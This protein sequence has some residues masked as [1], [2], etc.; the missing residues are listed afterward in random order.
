MNILHLKNYPILKQLQLEEALLRLSK[1]N[2]CLINEGSPPA[3]VMGISGKPEDL[4]HFEN[5]EKDPIPLIKR[6]SGG[7]TVVV[8]EQ[9][10]F[11]SFLCQKDLHD[12]A[13]YPEPIMRWSEE[14]YKPVL[15]HPQ[16][17]LRE[18]DY[19]IG[20]RKFGGNAQYLSRDRWLHHT[21]FLWDYKKERMDLLLHPKKTP[22]Y[23][24][25][26]SHE[27]FITK[28]SDYLPNKNIFVNGIKKVLQS[29]Y[30]ALEITIDHL[31]PL[32]EEPHR[33]STQII[34]EHHLC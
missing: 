24:A 17:S 34:P 1:E 25:A 8:D 13:P 32:L 31:L 21:T 27:D 30:Q 14:I 4:V 2:F 29:R 20:K 26:R 28:L 11:V 9:T 18:N 23:R 15:N 22:A 3:I 12:F 19:V 6:Y 7:G 5:L 10:I 33:K 16:F